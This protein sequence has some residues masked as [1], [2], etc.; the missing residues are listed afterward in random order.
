MSLLTFALVASAFGPA[1]VSSTALDASP[2][3]EFLAPAPSTAM[4][5]A[6]PVADDGE[7]LLSFT[8]VEVGAGMYAI[9][10]ID[11]VSID[12]DEDIDIFYG[13]ASLSLLKFLYIFG[14]YSNQSADFENT[15]T[16]QITLG[17][18]AHFAVMPNLSLYGEIGVLFSD[19][20]SDLEELDDSENGYRGAAGARWMAL[21]WDGGGL[22]LNGLIGTLS[23]DNRLGSDE[24][25][26]IYGAG[27][28]VH[29]IR[30]LSVGVN[31]EVVGDDD[32]LL[33]GVRWSF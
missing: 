12:E 24:D 9:D 22:E 1:P 27:A 11:G 15:D 32:L 3:A 23:L 30:F 18:G 5:P 28:R 6:A 4:A 17:A 25:P 14:E 19:V 16:D 21:P 33:G 2:L 26:F 13:R 29:F 31:Y 20:S 7:S 10:N 8:Y